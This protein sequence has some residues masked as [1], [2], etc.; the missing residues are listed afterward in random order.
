MT[1][2]F[3]LYILVSIVPFG[4]PYFCR[5][6][7][8]IH[9]SRISHFLQC[10][11]LKCISELLST[12]HIEWSNQFAPSNGSTLCL[13]YAPFSTSYTDTIFI[14][15]KN[16][17]EDLFTLFSVLPTAHSN[18]APYNCTQSISMCMLFLRFYFCYFS[19][20]LTQSTQTVW[21]G[22]CF[23]CTV[24]FDAMHIPI[25]YHTIIHQCTLHIH[26]TRWPLHRL[27]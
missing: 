2:T 11:N 12:N 22:L 15:Q 26:S 25:L 14:R 4:S 21:F 3:C 27:L 23:G 18:L 13:S 6:H 24:D 20:S 9:I 19:V 5:I 1:V 7:Q 10:Y 8:Q 17:C 16:L